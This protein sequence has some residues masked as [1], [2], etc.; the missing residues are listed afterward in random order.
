[1]SDFVH[2]TLSEYGYGNVETHIN[3]W[4]NGRVHQRGTSEPCAKAAAFMCAMQDSDEQMLCY[5]DAR[6]GVSIYGGMFNPITYKPFC[7][8]Y[9]FYAFGQL[10]KLGGQVSCEIDEN[11]VYGLA[12]TDGKSRAVMVSNISGEDRSFT[13]NLSSDMK[14]YVIDEDNLF[15]LTEISPKEFTIKN[16]QVFFLIDGELN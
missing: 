3:E 9:S 8:Y 14:V 16:N 12:A 1:M 13:T 5:Y 6:I 11:K 4:N 2:R 15:T 7:T 10:Y